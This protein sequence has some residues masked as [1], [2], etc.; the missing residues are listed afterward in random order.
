MEKECWARW[1]FLRHPARLHE[2]SIKMADREREREANMA[3]GLAW[4]RVRDPQDETESRSATCFTL[5][6]ISSDLWL[7]LCV[8]P[9]RW[10]LKIPMKFPDNCQERNNILGKFLCNLAIIIAAVKTRLNWNS[11]INC[12]CK[13]ECWFPIWGLSPRKGSHSNT[14]AAQN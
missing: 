6:C 2:F 11:P 9:P 5:K 10:H 8:C 7:P 14:T 12:G 3:K 4:V 1:L 13:W